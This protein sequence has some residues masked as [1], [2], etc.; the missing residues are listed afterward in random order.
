MKMTLEKLQNTDESKLPDSDHPFK[1]D[2]T[3]KEFVNILNE[4]AK[5][6][7]SIKPLNPMTNAEWDAKT[8]QI[9]NALNNTENPY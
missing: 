3:S 1:K 4:I 6:T 9:L 7:I 2:I 5:K 8:E